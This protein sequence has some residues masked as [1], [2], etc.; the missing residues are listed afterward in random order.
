MAID[1]KTLT[2]PLKDTSETSEKLH[3][4]FHWANGLAYLLLS[5]GGIAMVVP[6]IWMILSAFKQPSEVIAYPPIWIP[7]H[8]SIQ[9]FIKLWTEFYFKIYF[10]NSLIVAVTVTIAVSF[11]S[12]FIGYVLA[13]YQFPGQSMIFFLIITTMMIPWPTLLIPQYWIV[14]KLKWLNSYQALIVPSLYSAFGI[15]LARQFMHAIPDELLDA[16]RIDGASEPIVFLKIVLPLSG[17]VIAAVGILHF[18]WTWDSFIWPLVVTNSKEMF[19]LPI[20]LQLFVGQHGTDY[21]SMNAGSSVAVIPILI[22]FIFLQRYFIEG[23]TM[24]GL[25]A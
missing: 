7:A 8:P 1:T 10:I 22:I 2:A 9:A 23:I 18:L 6:F 4:R 19:T 17:P 5:L 21:V 12:I 24:S 20:G 3:R 16:G 14:L 15:F 13:K 25:K 11:T